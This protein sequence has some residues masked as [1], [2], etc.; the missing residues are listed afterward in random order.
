MCMISPSIKVSL[1]LQLIYYNYYFFL[2]VNEICIKGQK[3][4]TKAHTM[5]TT[6]A[7]KHQKKEEETKNY[8]LP[9][10][11]PNQS[12]KSTMDIN[13]SPIN[14]LVQDNKLHKNKYFSLWIENST[15]SKDLLF[16]SFQIVQKR[17]KGAALQTFF[18]FLPTKVSCQPSIVSLTVDCITQKTLKGENKSSHNTLVLSQCKRMW[19][20]DSS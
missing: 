8:S 15:F 5:Y 10:T 9:Q 3:G 18:H 11:N 16:L 13:F 6:T 1:C 20:I 17:H 19:S 7:K 2:S 12:M 14:S 4:S